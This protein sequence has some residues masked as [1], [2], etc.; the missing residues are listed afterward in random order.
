MY[1]RIRKTPSAAAAPGTYS[2]RGWLIQPSR[3]MVM[4]VGI[5]LRN[6]GTSIPVSATANSV[7]LKRNSYIANA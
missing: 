4:N 3:S 7:F 2:A 1:W 6:G 5:M